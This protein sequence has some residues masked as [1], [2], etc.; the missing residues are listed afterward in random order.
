MSINDNNE[1]LEETRREGIEQLTRWSNMVEFRG[2]REVDVAKENVFH[3]RSFTVVSAGS[4]HS[5]FYTSS[6]RG[7]GTSSILFL[8]LFDHRSDD[9]RSGGYVTLILLTASLDFSSRMEAKFIAGIGA[10]QAS[11]SK[12]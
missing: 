10:I 9:L 1:K 11:Q 7:K 3:R 5:D 4:T 2:D 6:K 8:R 12:A